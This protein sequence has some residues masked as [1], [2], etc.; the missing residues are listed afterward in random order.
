MMGRRFAILLTGAVIVLVLQAQPAWGVSVLYYA[1]HNAGTS[2]VPGALALEGLSGSTTTATSTAEFNTQ[3]GSG[4]WDLVIVGHHNYGSTDEAIATALQTY[5]TG[6]GK[7][8]CASWEGSTLPSMFDATE[9]SSN[10]TTISNDGHAL[11][12]GLGSSVSLSN[13]GWGTYARAYNPLGGATGVGPAGSG[14]AMVIGNG[15]RTIMSGPLFD[16]YS[17]LADGERLVGNQ[18]DYLLGTGPAPIPEPLTVCG[19]AFAL[20]GVYGYTRRRRAV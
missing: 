17:P 4:S 16:T 11:F 18:I 3:I 14:Y 19:V 9:V 6:G 1:D 7:A 12:D 15:G 5:L 20:A 2:A 10:Y 8:I 13:P